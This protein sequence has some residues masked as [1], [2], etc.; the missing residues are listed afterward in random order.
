MT[1]FLKE[2]KIPVKYASG[3]QRGHTIFLQFSNG[4]LINRSLFFRYYKC[5]MK[6]A[7]FNVTFKPAY[8]VYVAYYTAAV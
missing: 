6:L 1:T 7:L 2:M 5:Y 3:L 4:N 8:T